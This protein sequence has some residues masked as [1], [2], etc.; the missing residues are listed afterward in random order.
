LTNIT[1]PNS[2]TEIGN[3]V[4]GENENLSSLTIKRATS[5]GMTMGENWYGSCPEGNIVYQP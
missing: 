3:L 4:F 1:I 5:D 2:V